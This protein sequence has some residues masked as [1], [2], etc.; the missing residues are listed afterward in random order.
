[1][2]GLP[3]AP[4]AVNARQSIIA[5]PRVLK[6]GWR[7]KHDNEWE[8]AGAGCAHGRLKQSAAWERVSLPVV[9]EK[10]EEREG[11]E[12]DYSQKGK[13]AMPLRQEAPMPGRLAALVAAHALCGW[14]VQEMNDENVDGARKGLGERRVGH[15]SRF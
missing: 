12:S 8:A 1:M 15:R 3:C 4:S 13:K 9:G 5:C 14:V 11:Q 7:D 10:E 2:G 6:G